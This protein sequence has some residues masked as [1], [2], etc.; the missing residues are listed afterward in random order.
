MSARFGDGQ[1]LSPTEK[2]TLTAN[3]AK[4]ATLAAP[5]AR[6]VLSAATDLVNGS[7][8]VA[9][10]YLTVV[11]AQNFT[12]GS[13]TALQIAE[14]RLGVAFQAGATP[15][16]YVA[17][18]LLDGATI[19][20]LNPPLYLAASAIGYLGGATF[21]IRGLTAGTHTIALRV[22][23]DVAGAATYLRASTQSMFE[24]AEI[25]IYEVSA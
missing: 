21:Q 5:T 15:G 14:V 7:V 8:L 25:R 23:S 19:V 4:L 11:A 6:L 20:K 24:F 12:V 10:T 2:A 18:A 1:G 17:E 16:R 13:T 9:N 22:R 3:T